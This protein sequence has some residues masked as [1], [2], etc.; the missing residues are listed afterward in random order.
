LLDSVGFSWK[1]KTSESSPSS[2]SHNLTQP[3]AKSSENQQLWTEVK[4]LHEKSLFWE[5][6][7]L[8]NMSEN[9]V[10][11]SMIDVCSVTQSIP[12][13]FPKSVFSECTIE[14]FKAIHKQLYL[15]A[16][17]SG[18]TIAVRKHYHAK[19]GQVVG[20]KFGCTS[21]RC[22]RSSIQNDG[23]QDKENRCPKPHQTH[24][25]CSTES[26]HRC[27]WSITIR[28]DS[29]YGG[30]VVSSCSGKKH[31]YHIRQSPESISSKKFL[32][33]EE[34]AQLKLHEECRVPSAATRRV[35][36]Q[37][38]G[39]MLTRQQLHFMR[40]TEV[41]SSGSRMEKLF[42]TTTA[43]QLLD[44]LDRMEDVFYTA[45]VDDP[46]SNL[47]SIQSKG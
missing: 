1:S 46:D 30:F 40:Q 18:F 45:L 38:M 11:V 12:I 10:D 34:I 22:Y 29:S 26:S 24:S 23:S 41:D 27:P 16:R 9:T 28:Y 43:S 19:N 15:A 35:M 44:D 37:Q 17:K 47:Y 21:G 14:N 32:T 42:A 6:N 20:I 8:I 36:F 31:C 5:C 7:L 2:V 39:M 3:M 33:R 25:I 13:Q 4:S